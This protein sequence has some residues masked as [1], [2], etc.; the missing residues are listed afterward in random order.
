MRTTRSRRRRTAST[1][2]PHTTSRLRSCFFSSTDR[3]TA[4]THCSTLRVRARCS[5]TKRP[6]PMGLLSRAG[7]LLA[8]AVA[9]WC[10][11][12]CA[13]AEGG[14]G[15]LRWAKRPEFAAWMAG[16]RR[17]IHERPELAFEERET[18]ALVRRELDAM[19]VRYE[20]PVAGTGVVAA[21]GTGR[22]PFVALR[23]DMDA[24]PLQGT[25][26][27]LFQPG[28]EIGIGARKM[29]EAGAVDKVEAIFG[30][31]V[32]VMLPTGVVGSRA[33][34][35][36]AGCGFFEAVIT[37]KGGHAA[38]PQ[39]SVDPVLAASSVVLALQSLVS[40]EADPLDAQVVTVT[41]F[42]GGGG[43]LNVIPDSVTIGGTFR[44]FSNEG[45]AR[46]KRRIEEVIVAQ[47]AVHRCAAGVDFHAGGRPLLAPTTNSA[48]LH[49][50]FVAVATGTVG[51]GGVRGGMEPCMGS[52]D[53]AAFSEAVQGGSHFYFVGIRNE[54]A[55]SVHD[56]H[57]PLFRVD[58]GAL[59]YGAA[60]HATLAMTYLQ[61]QR[62]RGDSHDEL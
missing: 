23:A 10:R 43:A 17:A 62:P 26:I 29:V 19:G 45:F 41:R 60:M 48:A 46:L 50:H 58:E 61:Q 34:P 42:R 49:A 47:A 27:L 40:R 24:L 56:A 39:S 54:S 5:T 30:F 16:V 18:S 37:G 59:P 22:P 1:T 3:H 11:A 31:H 44:C 32:T 38:T 55:G 2:S 21:V 28:E 20:H 8:V 15:V 4:H 13:S 33:G 6:T 25:V 53:F 57:S 7:L 36:L 12:S 51:A 35:L 52:E 14:A 9:L